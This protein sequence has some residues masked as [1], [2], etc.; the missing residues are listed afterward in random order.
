M[1]ITMGKGSYGTIHEVGDGNIEVG[2]FCSIAGKVVA[3]T[4]GHNCDWVTTYP[5]PARQIRGEY[6][7]AKKIIGHPTKSDIYIGHDVWIGQA[8]MIV[9]P[10]YI[11]HGAVIGAASVIRGFV[12]P[13]TIVYGNPIMTYGKRFS[14]EIICRLL[15]IKW[16]FW[17]DEKIRENVHLLCSNRIR[18]FVD[19]H[20]EISKERV[21]SP[22]DR[23]D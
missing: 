16:W 2:N 11:G 22:D 1:A 23:I 7:E 9:A 19:A 20:S 21:C 3:V 12:E 6:P 13:Y 17:S 14:D 4:V 18:E 10:A 5:F 15:E 8:A